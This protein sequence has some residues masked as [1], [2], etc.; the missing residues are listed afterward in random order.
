MVKRNHEFFMGQTTAVPLIFTARCYAE[1]GI[2]MA[3]LSVRPSVFDI[4]V[5]YVVIGLQVGI[6]GKQFHG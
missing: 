4:E 6:L 2:A 1:R 3:K 5:P